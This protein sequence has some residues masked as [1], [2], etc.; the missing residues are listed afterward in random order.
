MS[1]ISTSSSVSWNP[2]KR[3]KDLLPTGEK[4]IPV[5]GVVAGAAMG[6]LSKAAN[7]CMDVNGRSSLYS[8]ESSFRQINNAKHAEITTLALMTPMVLMAG[9]LAY[10]L[11]FRDNNHNMLR[12]NVSETNLTAMLPKSRL[13]KASLKDQLEIERS[14]ISGKNICAIGALWGASF[15]TNILMKPI[16]VTGLDP[17]GHVIMKSAATVGMLEAMDYVVKSGQRELAITVAVLAALGDAV[18]IANTV[19]C[20]HTVADVVTGGAIALGL[21]YTIRAATS[22]VFQYYQGLNVGGLRK[23]VKGLNAT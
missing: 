4:I 9:N 10:K 22:K 23:H 2:L 16:K 12:K 1:A 14:H 15:V 21:A 13:K 7:F 6:L 3:M 11:Y 19:G 20:S 5:T 17:S 18:L 8:L